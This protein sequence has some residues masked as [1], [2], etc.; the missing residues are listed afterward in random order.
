MPIASKM[1]NVIRTLGMPDQNLGASTQLDAEALARADADST[2]QFNIDAEIT[3]R[4][5]ADL[6]E[7]TARSNADSTLQSNL[8]SEITARTN[9]DST[10]M[11]SIQTLGANT[12]F[13]SE[14][15]T[16]T[17]GVL[18]PSTDK[19]IQRIIASSTNLDTIANPIAGEF[20]II[21]NETASP[22]NVTNNTG[23][24]TTSIYTG[25]GAPITLSSNASLTLVY[26]ATLTRWMIVGGTGGGEAVT[27]QISQVSHGFSVGQILYLNGSTYALAKADAA[28]TAESTGIVS[29]IFS[30]D[31]FQLTEIGY[32]KGLS[33]LTA[34]NV[35]FLSDT[36]SG[37]LT[38]TEPT[39]IG[40]VT[41]PMLLA[42]STTSGY[43]LNYRGA[44]VGGANARA[45]FVLSNNATVTVQNVSLYEAGDLAGWVYIDAATRYR[46]YVNAKWAKNGAGTDY[47]I[48]VMTTGDT[49]PLG[50]SMTITSAGL[51]QLTLPSIS[52]YISAIIN[53]ALN[54][55]AIGTAYPLTVSGDSII[56]GTPTVL[57]LTSYDTTGLTF[58]NAINFEYTA[59]NSATILNHQHYFVSASGSSPYAVTLP[60]A[61]GI[62]GRSYVIKSNMDIGVTLT[63]NTTSSQTLDGLTSK[64]LARF[65]AINVIS[66]GSHWEIF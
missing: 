63:L 52:G 41:K 10:L 56:N 50:F 55:P 4:S 45:Q 40:S 18:T 23:A 27:K 62:A 36:V 54:A 14:A 39:V 34:G 32:A 58:N 8:N 61:V 29:N 5:N 9:A 11:A 57:G 38:A 33:G 1:G 43:V 49:P 65:E 2:L 17:A 22:I 51:I 37:A 31:M 21:I 66:N 24:S 19:P 12:A 48:N 46:F 16:V 53:Y 44:V 15:A 6:A 20:K 35:Y 30:A 59:V 60:T 13:A 47:N 25:T 7:I 28:N 26:D 3:A 64:S 42:D